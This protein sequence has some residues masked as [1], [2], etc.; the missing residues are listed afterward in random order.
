MSAEE[1]SRAIV[2][3]C[4]RGVVDGIFKCMCLQGSISSVEQPASQ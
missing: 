2:L 3:C 4:R 1:G